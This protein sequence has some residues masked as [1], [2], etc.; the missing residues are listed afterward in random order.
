MTP[1][2]AET[3]GRVTKLLPSCDV[4]AP[5]SKHLEGGPHVIWVKVPI[6]ARFVTLKTMDF[7]ALLEDPTGNAAAALRCFVLR[8]V[9]DKCLGPPSTTT[10]TK[11]F[12]SEFEVAARAYT[13]EIAAEISEDVACKRRRIEQDLAAAKQRYD[14]DGAAADLKMKT[15]WSYLEILEAAPRLEQAG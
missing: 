1:Q 7:R 14:E 5:P 6:F 9:L 12:N 3:L 15:A 2:E 10:L 8:S 11:L 4:Y 13:R